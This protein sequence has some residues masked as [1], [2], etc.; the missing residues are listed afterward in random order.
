MLNQVTY[1]DGKVT[2]LANLGWL[3]RRTRR[4]GGL[5]VQRIE[6]TAVGAEEGLLKVYFHGGAV[7]ECEFADRK[8]LCKDFLR[9][10]RWRHY[11][12]QFF[13]MTAEGVLC[14]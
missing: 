13:G 2:E 1:P 9:L 11:P 6:A 7:Y 5:S 3:Y 8:V 12:Q 14:T 4:R 10:P